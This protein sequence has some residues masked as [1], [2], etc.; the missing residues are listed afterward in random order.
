MGE[1][2]SRAP[3]FFHRE[4]RCRQSRIVLADGLEKRAQQSQRHQQAGREGN[5]S[6]SRMRP[7]ETTKRAHGPRWPLAVSRREQGT[8]LHTMLSGTR[9]RH[10]GLRPERFF[11]PDR[12][13]RG[14][15][16]PVLEIVSPGELAA[17]SCNSGLRVSASE[18]SFAESLWTCVVPISIRSPATIPRHESYRRPAAEVLKQATNLATLQARQKRRHQAFMGSSRERKEAY[19]GRGAANHVLLYPQSCWSVLL[20][21]FRRSATSPRPSAAL[22]SQRTLSRVVST[23]GPILMNR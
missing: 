14:Y 12:V 17:I 15:F 6:T 16:C 19:Q 5:A 13:V 11:D 4:P 18:S 3:L 10:D 23:L 20:V 7:R 21:S 8:M 9:K 2:R 22:S 1:E